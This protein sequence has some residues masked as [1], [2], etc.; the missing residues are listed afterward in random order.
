[1]MVQANTLFSMQPGRGEKRI[2]TEALLPRL[3]VLFNYERTKKLVPQHSAFSREE[4]IA[5]AV[6]LF[7]RLIAEEKE[8]DMRPSREWSLEYF[9]A[10][11]NGPEARREFLIDEGVFSR[12]NF[13]NCPARVKPQMEI[14]NIS[15]HIHDD[16]IRSDI[17]E[18]CYLTFSEFFVV[19]N[20]LSFP[21]MA[22]IITSLAV[23]VPFL[24]KLRLSHP[25]LKHSLLLRDYIEQ[26][27]TE[28][29]KIDGPPLISI[30]G[31][32]KGEELVPFIK[33]NI[34]VLCFDS[35]QG[36]ILKDFFINTFEQAGLPAPQVI[37]IGKEKE[38]D[39]SVFNTWRHLNYPP[40]VFLHTKID[41]SQEYTIPEQYFELSKVSAANYVL[42]EMAAKKNLFRNMAAVSKGAIVIVDGYPTCDAF[43]NVILPVSDRSNVI[44]VGHDAIVSHLL[45]V[46]PVEIKQI[47]EEAVPYLYWQSKV[48]G[49][50]IPSPFFHKLQVTVIGRKI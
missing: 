14:M 40:T 33:R 42:H 38:V 24:R 2:Q 31:P 3:F 32:G 27:F 47:A 36:V 1:M 35:N 9:Q 12:E 10:Y 50:P 46:N 7:K 23:K 29:K 26:I 16:P 43:D 20:L 44:I 6:A 13:L 28:M 19:K 45:C 48:I 11:A 4:K 22:D 30:F 49:P 18:M 15:S 25:R 17:L 8:K 5:K 21:E 37:P 34:S 41:F 39:T